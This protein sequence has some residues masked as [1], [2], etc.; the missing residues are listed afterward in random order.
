MKFACLLGDVTLEVRSYIHRG[1]EGGAWC[2]KVRLSYHRLPKLTCIRIIYVLSLYA[3]WMLRKVFCA[4]NRKFIDLEESL[5]PTALHL[6]DVGLPLAHS[7]QGHHT[8]IDNT[9]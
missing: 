1:R 5:L 7:A 4:Q 3:H 8:F 2:G 9:L 6:L